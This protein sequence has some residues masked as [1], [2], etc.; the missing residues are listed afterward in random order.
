[1][2]REFRQYTYSGFHLRLLISDPVMYYLCV[3]CRGLVTN[4]GK[5]IYLTVKIILLAHLA[6]LKV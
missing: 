2:L 3:Q 6:K 4:K 5:Y 1:M